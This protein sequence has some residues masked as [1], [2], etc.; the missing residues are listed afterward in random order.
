VTKVLLASALFLCISFA[1]LN[2]SVERVAAEI[3]SLEAS[4]G[5]LVSANNLARDQKE[6]LFS[7]EAVGGMA[8]NKL[9]LHVPLLEQYSN[10]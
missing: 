5:K 4:H 10:L 1:L 8:G 7:L 2:S 9:A 6:R 3:E